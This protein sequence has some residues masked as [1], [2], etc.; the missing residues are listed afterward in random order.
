MERQSVASRDRRAE[1]RLRRAN[2]EN[3]LSPR[4]R[5]G[6]GRPD[7]RKTAFCEGGGEAGARNA[8][9]SATIR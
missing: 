9:G 2:V 1:N 5:R 7:L 4:A 6:L 8:A 3:A